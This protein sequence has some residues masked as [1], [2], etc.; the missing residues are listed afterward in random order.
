MDRELPVPEMSKR[1]LIS[2]AIAAGLLAAI[3]LWLGVRAGKGPPDWVEW[4]SRTLAAGDWTVTLDRGRVTGT[5]AGETWQPDPD[6]RVQDALTADMD[7][8]GEAELLLL[9]WRQGRY[10][11]S[12]PFWVTEAEDGDR[13]T[14]HIDIYDLGETVRPRW[15]ASDIGLEAEAWRFSETARL[16]IT[17]R[18]GAETAWDWLS[19]GL[20]RVELRPETVTVAVLGELLVHRQIYD[21]YLRTE[22]GGFGG[23]FSE[24]EPVLSAYDVTALHL[25]TPLVDDP[26]D[27]GTYPVF[28]TPA[29]AGEAILAAGFDV[30]SCASNHALDRGLAGIDRTAGL[31]REVV[32]AGIQPEADGAYRPYAMLER[33]GIRIAVLSYTETTN[34]HA[35]PE[36]AP[37]V[38]HTLDDEA[39]VRGGLEGGPGGGRRGAGLR[40]LGR[41]VRRD[42]QRGANRLG[43]DLRRGRSRRGSGDPSP[44]PPALGMGGGTGRPRDPGLLLPGQLPL[45]PDRRGLPP[46]QPGGLH[47]DPDPGGRRRHP[48]APA[49]RRN[50][51]RPGPLLRRRRAFVGAGAFGEACGESGVQSGRIYNPPLQGNRRRVRRG[52]LYIRPKP[53]SDSRRATMEKA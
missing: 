38:L 20:E 3:A 30:V 42:A 26:A 31:F 51:L 40:P 49:H 36:D 21:Y 10:G 48:R 1:I 43:P 7:R 39:R 50:P 27:Y 11:E 13:W 12:R 8:D 25:E 47:V 35:L 45:G 16:V 52:G 29:E 23:M 9:T 17:D 41:R 6:T 44:R 15:M 24:L 32:C 14:Q 4:Q 28:G 37:Y 2:L 46:G 19:W 53:G 5:A 34:G 18:T 22:N 33:N